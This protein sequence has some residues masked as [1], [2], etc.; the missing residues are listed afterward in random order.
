MVQ[1]ELNL[2]TCRACRRPTHCPFDTILMIHVDTNTRL[3]S[4]S[5]NSTYVGRQTLEIVQN[6]PA[7]IQLP[8]K[9]NLVVFKVNNGTRETFVP[10]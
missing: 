2:I 1:V 10:F 7:E 8:I 4:V 9:T 5:R 6:T 3:H